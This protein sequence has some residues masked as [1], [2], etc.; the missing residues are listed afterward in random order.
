MVEFNRDF[1]IDPCSRINIIDLRTGGGSGGGGSAGGHSQ[2]TDVGTSENTFT[3][4]SDDTGGNVSLTFGTALA[5]S[6]LWDNANTRFTLSDD[7]RTEG[8]LAV[9]GQVYIAADHVATDSDGIL[10]IGRNGSAWETF[11]WN[12]TAN[13]YQ[14]IN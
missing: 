5:E 1:W 14:L 12:D 10:N 3:L 7:V 2:N 8:N 4:D 6:L 9:V 11:Q 13:E